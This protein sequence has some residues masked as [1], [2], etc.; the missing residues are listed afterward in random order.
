MPDDDNAHLIRSVDKLN[1]TIEQLRQ[2]LVRRDV[3]DAHR[4]AD[5]ERV[6]EVAKD[7][8]ELKEWRKWLSRGVLAGLF[9]SI[10]PSL[11]MLYITTQVV[12]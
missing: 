8:D 11:I 4:E 10:V 9:I 7:V 6:R 5:L 12:R 3:Y 1:H 2:E